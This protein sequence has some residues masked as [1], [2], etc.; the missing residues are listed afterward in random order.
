L[1]IFFDRAQKKGIIQFI[2]QGQ[3]QEPVSREMQDTLE[4]LKVLKHYPY[5]ESIFPEGYGPHEITQSILTVKKQFDHLLEEQLTLK[6][7]IVRISPLGDFSLSEIQAIEEQSKKKVFFYSTKRGKEAELPEDFI[8]VNTDHELDFYMQL[9]NQELQVTGLNL[10]TIHTSLSDLKFRLQEVKELIKE[11]ENEFK[12]FAPFTDFLRES[13]IIETN[14]YELISAKKSVGHIVDGSLFSVEAWVPKKKANQLLTIVGQMSVHFEE[15]RIEEHDKIPTYMENVGMGKVGEDLV[16]IYDTPAHDDKDPSRWVLFAFCIFF[17]MIVSDAGYGF[18]Y[19]ALGLFLK[20]RYPKAK[21]SFKR[22]IFLINM[23]ASFTVGWGVLTGSYFSISMTPNQ[24]LSK[25][26]LS[27]YLVHKKADYHFAQ[28]DDVYDEWVVRYPDLKTVDSSHDAIM[29]AVELAKGKEVYKMQAE[30]TDN[31]LLELSLLIGIIHISLSF[32]RNIPKAWAGI[33]WIFFMIGGYL[34]FPSF[35]NAT[36]MM[37]FLGI[38]SKPL[39]KMIGGQLLIGGASLAIILAVIQHR[40][41]GLAEILASIQVFADVLSYLR[42]YALG[43]AGMIM[44]ATFN[45]LGRDIGFVIGALVTI[46]GHITNIVLGIMGGVI[47]GLRLNFLEWYHYSFSGGG[48]LFHPLAL[49]KG[50][51]NHH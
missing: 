16:H 30:F 50:K 3:H 10:I 18:I 41:K 27:S 8:L 25:Y 51:W 28:K 35:L 45:D 5:S 40:L 48:K 39:S 43:L 38:I 46:S 15:I 11:C 24:V 13:L 7:E 20:F 29:G 4:A 49:L 44:A 1:G 9:S 34:Y 37:N 47:H 19:L 33:G 22:T 42:L 6:T 2:P 17:A 32:A 23:A 36:S 31:I 26:S 21:G 12:T 14:N